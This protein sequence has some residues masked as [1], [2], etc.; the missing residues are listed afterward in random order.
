MDRLPGVIFVTGV[1]EDVLAIKEARAKNIP[2]IALADS[3]VDPREVDYVIPANEDA[4]S[5]L[6]I[7]MAYA[8]KTILDAKQKVLVEKAKVEKTIQ[9]KK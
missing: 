9:E 7:M 1:I 4:V 3:N 6:K 8:I 2:V 5:S